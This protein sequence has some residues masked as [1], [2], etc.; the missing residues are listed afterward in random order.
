MRSFERGDV[1]FVEQ[2][3]D[4]LRRGAAISELIRKRRRLFWFAAAYSIFA[5]FLP[6]IGR[7]PGL[8]GPMGLIAA[9]LWMMVF[10]YESELRLLMMIGKMKSL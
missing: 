4:D 6:L 7:N 10:K 2:G 5:L 9:F 3:I 8:G 1:Q